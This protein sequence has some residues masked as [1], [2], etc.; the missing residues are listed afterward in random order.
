[1]IFFFFSHDDND[2]IDVIENG[3]NGYSFFKD[4]QIDSRSGPPSAI[5]MPAEDLAAYMYGSSLKGSGNGKHRLPPPSNPTFD[6]S[7]GQQQFNPRMNSPLQNLLP[8]TVLNK[9]PSLGQ[10]DFA[11]GASGSRNKFPSQQGNFP[12]R[13]TMNNF[14]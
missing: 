9:K 14:G 1:M 5:D 10:S 7:F 3:G 8:N 11:Q 6:D 2:D 4:Q 12:S 13:S